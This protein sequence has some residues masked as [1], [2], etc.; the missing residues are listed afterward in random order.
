MTQKEHDLRT[1]LLVAYAALWSACLWGLI[2]GIPDTLGRFA[3]QHKSLAQGIERF[4]Q[5]A[6]RWARGG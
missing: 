4:W 3:P 6:H 5:G 1:A 2:W